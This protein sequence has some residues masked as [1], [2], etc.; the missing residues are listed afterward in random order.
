[1]VTV[2]LSE[3][4]SSMVLGS[5]TGVATGS[6]LKGKLMNDHKANKDNMKIYRTGGTELADGDS[7]NEG[8]NLV[9]EFIPT[10][11]EGGRRRRGSR[12]SRR[13]HRRHR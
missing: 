5:I 2:Y 8:E 4:H 13:A 9:I 3:M 11:S 12:K 1:M 7:L 10:S 6:E